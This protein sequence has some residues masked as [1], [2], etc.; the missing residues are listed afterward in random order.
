MRHGL[1][2]HGEE[3]ENSS[4]DENQKLWYLDPKRCCMMPVRV[5]FVCMR[6]LYPM[7]RDLINRLG[8][9]LSSLTVS[10]C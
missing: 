4:V 8:S 5:T 10:G 1:G 3:Y 2:K 9:G 6:R 7:A